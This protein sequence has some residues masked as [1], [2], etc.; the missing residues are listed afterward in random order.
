MNIKAVQFECGCIGLIFFDPSERTDEFVQLKACDRDFLDEV[1]YE[2][3]R[4]SLSGRIKCPDSWE[5]I[6]AEKLN[7]I[8]DELNSL[9]YNGYKFRQLKNLLK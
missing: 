3:Y 8:L 7:G 4:R 5:E 6:S 9:V 1:E 2:V